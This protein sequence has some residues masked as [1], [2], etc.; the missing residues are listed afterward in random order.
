M[1]NLAAPLI[2]SCPCFI[3]TLF[4]LS[5]PSINL[6]PLVPSCISGVLSPLRVLGKSLELSC[7]LRYGLCNLL[8][9]SVLQYFGFKYYSVYSLLFQWVIFVLLLLSEIVGKLLSDFAQF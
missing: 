6:V 1:S 5:N 2:N 4:G 8:Q 3:Q 9:C 7:V